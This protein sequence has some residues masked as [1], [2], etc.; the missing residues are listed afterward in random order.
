LENEDWAFCILNRKTEVKNY[1]IDWQEFNL[2]DELSKRSFY[3]NTIRYNIRNLWTKKEE[4]NT[5]NLKK[6]TI[7][8]HDILTYRLSTKK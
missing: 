2:N 8:G 1:V 7:F 5:K 4:G 6:I 3:F